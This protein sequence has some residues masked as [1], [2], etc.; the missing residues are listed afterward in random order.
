[1]NYRTL[2]IIILLSIISSAKAAEV[3]IDVK[4]LARNTTFFLSEN[5][6]LHK[7]PESGVVKMTVENLPTLIRITSIE[8]S[9]VKT[10]HT[11]WLTGDFLTITG[12]IYETIVVLPEKNG[13]LL[14]ADSEKDWKQMKVFEDPQFI[15]SRPFLVYLAGKLKYQDPENLEM[16]LQKTQDSDFEFWASR[17]IASFLDN[18]MD[19]GYDP[20]TKRFDNFTATNAAGEKETFYRPE[21]GYLLIDFASTSC[22]PC[23]TAIDQLVVLKE[24]YK[25]KLQIV[26]VWNDDD[27]D[28]WLNAAKSQKDKITWTN[29]RDDSKAIFYKFG[30]TVF[31]TYLLIDQ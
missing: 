18:L 5:S 26:S 11:L 15:P 3:E 14:P 13:V 7:I 10:L 28:T 1:M 6:V 20:F 8:K 31:P 19:V 30:I 4:D 23:L 17:K 29:L 27:Q 25:D 22:R 2:F 21:D 16:V 12:N 9:K 24:K